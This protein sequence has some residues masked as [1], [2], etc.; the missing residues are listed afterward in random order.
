MARGTATAAD[1]IITD[2]KNCTKKIAYGNYVHRRFFAF[3]DPYFI[4]FLS[5]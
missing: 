1:G 3:Y 2:G 5:S 4:Q